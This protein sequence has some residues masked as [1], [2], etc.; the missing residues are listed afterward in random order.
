MPQGANVDEMLDR[1]EGLK[2]ALLRKRAER[3][4]RDQDAQPEWP[5]VNNCGSEYSIDDD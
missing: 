3:H 1:I 2:T 4:R 5:H